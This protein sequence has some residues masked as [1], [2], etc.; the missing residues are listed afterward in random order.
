M[1]GRAAV[2]EDTVMPENRPTSLFRP[3]R[4]R[5]VG[6]SDKLVDGARS[7]APDAVVTWKEHG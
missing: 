6:A 2:T 1:T 7:E 4:V 3:R 5:L